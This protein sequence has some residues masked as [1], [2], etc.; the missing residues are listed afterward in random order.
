MLN[1]S[2][3]LRSTLIKYST[4]VETKTVTAVCYFNSILGEVKATG[5]AV[6]GDNDTFNKAKGRKLARA[7]AELNAYAIYRE[8]LYNYQCNLMEKFQNTSDKLFDYIEHQ[9]DYINDIK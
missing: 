6:C 5:Y 8:R 7:R 3:K 2:F 1:E 4:D 9:I